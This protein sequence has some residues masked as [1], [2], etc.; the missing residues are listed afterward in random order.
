MY[1]LCFKPASH[2]VDMM[3]Q[4]ERHQ[5]SFIHSRIC[6]SLPGQIQCRK[7]HQVHTTHE[8]LLMDELTN[9]Q[10]NFQCE[11][12]SLITPCVHRRSKRPSY[13]N[14]HRGTGQSDIMSIGKIDSKFWLQLD[15][16]YGCFSVP[17]VI[18]QAIE[19]NLYIANVGLV[20]RSMDMIVW[21]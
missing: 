14:T 19:G 11:S 16:V 21:L 8:R 3:W 9:C 6:V 18:C 12:N 13:I 5:R 15:T 4:Y 20:D 2:K 1:I 17:N 7:V 10:I